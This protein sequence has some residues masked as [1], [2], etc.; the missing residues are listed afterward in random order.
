[1]TFTLWFMGRPAAGKSTL[2]TRV[3]TYL[4]EQGVQVE[5]LDGDEIRR[6]LHPDLGYTRE[7]RATNNRR[8]AFLCKLLNRNGIA[9]VTGMITPFRDAQQKA[10]QIVEPDGDFVLIYVKCSIEEAARRDPKNLYE[11]AE[12]GEIENFTG[13]SHPFQPPHDPDIAVDTE[14]HSVDENVSHVLTRLHELDVLDEPAEESYAFDL[15]HSEERKIKDRLESLGYIGDE[16][17]TE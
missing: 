11:Q 7:D 2:A 9:T 10:R 5:N 8:T 4:R 16:P 15:A 17:E 1:M 3:E 6:N 12:R 13:V 14:K